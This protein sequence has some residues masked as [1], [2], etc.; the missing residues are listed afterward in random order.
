LG[1]G[2]IVLLQPRLYDFGLKEKL[3]KLPW[4][5]LGDQDISIGRVAANE[6]WYCVQ[7]L[8]RFV[9]LLAQN[10]IPSNSM[11]SES[12]LDLKTGSVIA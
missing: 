7:P 8:V 5:G 2:E 3:G 1:I 11:V 12:T 9:N 10:P 6:S 4:E